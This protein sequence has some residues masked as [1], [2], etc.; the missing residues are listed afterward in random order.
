MK[1]KH[2][3]LASKLAKKSTHH[4]HHLG[5]VI[6]KG[7]KI[8]GVGFNKNKTSPRS[9]NAFST[10]HAEISAILNTDEEDLEGSEIYIFRATKSGKLGLSRP[11]IF[12]E[13]MLRS[14]GIKKIYYTTTEGFQEEIYE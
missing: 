1:L 5:A 9:N 14:V 3:Q 11:C 10:L 4:Q 2:F 7:N 12:C 8:L 13:K 6:T